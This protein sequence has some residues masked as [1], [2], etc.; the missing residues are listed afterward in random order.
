MSLEDVSR[1]LIVL[2][3]ADWMFTAV[4]YVTARRLREPALTERATTSAI[5]SVIATIAAWL[6][7]ARLGIVALDN[8]TAVG[9]LAVALILVSAPQFIWT[10][11]LAAGRFR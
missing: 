9:L 5:L 8:G 3:A 6:G 11:S 10:I 1:L 2:A 7:A 4:I